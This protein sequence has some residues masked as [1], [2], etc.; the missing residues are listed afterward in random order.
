MQ[1]VVYNATANAP[2]VN[3]TKYAMVSGIYLTTA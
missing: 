3:G 1:F 2:W